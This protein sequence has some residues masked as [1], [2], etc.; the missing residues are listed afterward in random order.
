MLSLM[1]VL[2]RTEAFLKERGS[3]SARMD[4]RLLLCHV[5]KME[6]M[7]LFLNFDKPLTR[8]ELVALREPV[9]R[10]GALEP[11]AY[12]LGER[13]FYSLPFAVG[14]GV[15]IPRP[16]TETLVEAALP[17]CEPAAGGEPVFVA[18]VGTGSG[19]VG[20]TLAKE[21]PAVR[22]FATDTSREALD[23]ARRNAEALGVKDRVALLLGD[24]LEPIPEGRPIDVIVSNPPYI[25]SAEIETLAPDVKDYEPRGALDGGPD[26][27]EVYRR[28]V[29]A[30]A[31]RARRAVL[32]EIGHD[33]GPDVAAL[34]EAAG[35]VDVTIKQDLGRRDRVVLGRPADTR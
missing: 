21:Q 4:A 35:L 16:D 23:Y 33:Q 24:L 12:I 13:E 9:R 5:L 3:E 31:A 2:Q 1:E 32:V 22:L 29:P 15:L 14:P 19:C 20:L 18:D 7:Q 11:M 6:Q 27:L 25:R 26:G 28:L 8:D 34:F 10:R 30:A 17:F